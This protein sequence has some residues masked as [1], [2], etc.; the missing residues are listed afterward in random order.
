[1]QQHYHIHGM[2]QITQQVERI[3]SIRQQQVVAIH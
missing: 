2:E 3:P 1:V